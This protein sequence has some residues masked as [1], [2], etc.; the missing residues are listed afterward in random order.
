MLGV[1]PHLVRPAVPLVSTVFLRSDTHWRAVH[2][3]WASGRLSLEASWQTLLLRPPAP[4][5][6]AAGAPA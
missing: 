5:L 6:P 4:L 1:V 2:V 3:R